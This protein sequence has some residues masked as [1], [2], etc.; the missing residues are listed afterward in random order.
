MWAR[1]AERLDQWLW[2]ANLDTLTTAKRRDLLLV[3]LGYTISRD[4]GDPQF[5]LRV[6]GLV[7]TSLLTLVPF[8]ALGF[9]LLKAFDVHNLIEPMLFK[10]F[11]PLGSEAA[12]LTATLLGFVDNIKVGVLGTIGLGLLLYSAISLIQKIESGF[13]FIWKVQR[14]RSLMRRFSEYLSV[15]VV[16]PLV[17][18]AAL[19]LTAGLF[20]N[21][22]VQQILALQPF[23]WLL[24]VGG[25]LLPYVLISGAFAFLYAFMPNTRVRIVPALTGGLFAGV[26]WQTASWVF[27]ALVARLTSYN[28]IYSSFAILIFLLIWLYIGWLILLLG[29]HV[30]YLVQHPDQLARRPRLPRMGGR[31]AE[32]IALSIMALVARHFV[33]GRAPWQPAALVRALKL[34]PEHIYAVMD[35]LVKTGWLAETGEEAQAGLL[36]T[37]DLATAKVGDLLNSVRSSEPELE[38]LDAQY[39]TPAAVGR[40]MSAL[41]KAQTEALAKLS[42]RDL[43]D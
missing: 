34:P 20:N 12:K 1:W 35:L 43:A 8:L 25:R 41:D 38:T 42:L 23:G 32:Q 39:P 3:R 29:C 30:S 17:V 18:V 5:T 37:R 26:I 19:G 36:P 22:V 24:E 13:N 10:L 6:M 15:L 31:I 16:G 14:A 28:A 9:S 27:A 4:L 7:Y 40:A 21:T 11:E 33:E 2:S